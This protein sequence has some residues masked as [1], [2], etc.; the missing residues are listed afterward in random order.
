MFIL[1]LSMP[2]SARIDTHSVYNNMSFYHPALDSGRSDLDDRSSGE[3]WILYGSP[4]NLYHH[5]TCAFSSRPKPLACHPTRMLTPGNG[6][7]E[8]AADKQVSFEVWSLIDY[9]I[10]YDGHVAEFVKTWNGDAQIAQTC[11]LSY[12]WLRAQHFRCLFSN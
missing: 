9:R 4:V 7:P 1:C 11:S 8:M 6:S 10:R 5:V 3:I 2:L 12:N